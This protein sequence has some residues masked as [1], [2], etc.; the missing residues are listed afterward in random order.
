MKILIIGIENVGV[1]HGWVLSDACVDVTHVVQK[2]TL[3]R[4]LNPDLC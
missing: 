4:K 2:G 3:A 1:M